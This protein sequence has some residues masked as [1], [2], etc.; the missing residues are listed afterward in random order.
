MVYD[1]LDY[2]AIGLAVPLAASLYAIAQAGHVGAA[3]VVIVGLELWALVW[4]AVGE[5]ES[6]V[7]AAGTQTLFDLALV[8]AVL[9]LAEA[10]RSRRAWMSEMHER[11]RRRGLSRALRLANR[12]V[13]NTAIRRANLEA[14]A[15][16]ASTDIRANRH[17]HAICVLPV[18]FNSVRYRV[19]NRRHGG[20]ERGIQ[21]ASGSAHE[22]LHPPALGVELSDEIGSTRH[23][24]IIS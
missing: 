11:L 13:R 10:L 4:R 7:S 22:R 14:L 9:L 15:Y 17:D 8:A 16:I 18:H 24:A 6:V 21:G 2:P 3:V 1:V 20:C 19:S 12:P 5:D 23:F